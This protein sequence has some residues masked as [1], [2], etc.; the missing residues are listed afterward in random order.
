M[1][2][3]TRALYLSFLFCLSALGIHNAALAAESERVDTGKV[4]AQ[5]I[6]SH[7]VAAPG[8]TIYVALSTE[9]DDHWHTYWRNPGDSGEPV[10]I[11]WML[12][13]GVTA[14]EIIWPLPST[15]ATGP[16]IN[17]GFEGA[18]LFPVAV[19]LPEA[20]KDGEFLTLDADVYYLVCKDI[21]IPE[22]G[23]L[24]IDIL[25]GA[26]EEDQLS[27]SLINTA[28]AEAP[29]ENTDVKSGIV[30]ANGSI[31]MDFTNLPEG[32]FSQA[33]FFP[34]DQGLILPAAPQIVAIGEN[35]LRI[36]STA[37]FLWDSNMPETV[38]G[39][40]KF[41]N[42][43]TDTGII[44]AA[45]IGAA[46]DVG[47]KTSLPNNGLNTPKTTFFG[48][49]IGA[50]IGGLILNLMPCVFP[51]IS[52][53]ALSLARSAHTDR[54]HARREGWF[55]TF[56]VIA[57]FLVLTGLLLTLKAAGSNLGW[58]FQLQSPIM[59][60]VLALLLFLIGLNL[61]G[62][63]EVSL[64]GFENTGSE[65]TRKGGSM[66]AF[67]TG[68]L[69]VVVA[70]PCTAPFMAGAIGYALAQP[71][72]VTL[73]VFMALAIGFAAPFL[74][75]SY[76]PG[77]LAK[78]PK[79]GPW[80]IRFRELLAFPM[81]A[82]TIW[83]ISVLALQSG[84]E[85]VTLILLAMLGLGFAI[86]CL[87]RKALVAKILGPATFLLAL[88]APFTLKTDTSTLDSTAH[89][90]TQVWSAEAVATL[91]AEGRPVFVDFTAAWCVTCKVNE[92]LVLEKQATQKLFKDSNTAVL[93]ADWTNK[94]DEIAQELARHGRS[95]V[96]L[97]LLYTPGHN[98]VSPQILPQ[99]LT[100]TVLREAINKATL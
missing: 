19:T 21:C 12:P 5:L 32:G 88:Y 85:G 81:L 37:D 68:A 29:K 73:T 82:A 6:S 42:G 61:L 74:L 96:P 78:L 31:S 51:V 27:A 3:F 48:A 20:A 17:Y 26:P 93:I 33:Y 100:E 24:S 40:L 2:Y 14:G 92:K 86:W 99:I 22:Q 69:A 4:V 43:G 15:I 75:L 16:I 7:N 9:L 36:S 77:L 76:M 44:V 67:F 60:G 59:V 66:G 50:I 54:S 87:K 34:Y 98:A 65:L 84:F 1:T 11:S 56:G 64:G 79:P 94:N 49:I 72:I 23:Q 47:V 39:V 30:N 91:R 38:Q 58:G 41:Q 52:I 89:V 18:P 70:T 90:E 25:I 57:T 95:G 71:D 10:Q 97:Y 62:V 13:N 80:M 63:F 55:Y 83:L 46:L 35:G 28:L 45:K 8:D 53:K